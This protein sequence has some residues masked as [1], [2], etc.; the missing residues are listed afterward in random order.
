MLRLAV[1]VATL[2][3]AACHHRGPPA[4]CGPIPGAPT[5]ARLLLDE[6]TE[7][8]IVVVSVT[9]GSTGNPLK[10]ARVILAPIN[11]A[12]TT[13]ARGRAR[14]AG[15]PPG[16]YRLAVQAIG[17]WP[18]VDSLELAQGGGRVRAV[19][20]FLNRMCL[21]EGATVGPFRP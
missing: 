19:Q 9:D 15:V 7:A 11:L 12:I 10:A 8:G 17:Y 4:G 14:L 1:V 6:P 21:Y 13:D 20:L 3:L 18:Y 2:C 5:K 16:R